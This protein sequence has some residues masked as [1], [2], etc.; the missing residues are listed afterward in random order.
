MV[1]DLLSKASSVGVEGPALAEEWAII[2]GIATVAFAGEYC[3]ETSY[4]SD[5]I[6]ILQRALIR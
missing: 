3:R 4:I 6:N 2:K 5:D 1:R